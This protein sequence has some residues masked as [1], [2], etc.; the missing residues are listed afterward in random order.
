[1]QVFEEDKTHF[2]IRWKKKLAFTSLK[3]YVTLYTILQ[4]FSQVNILKEYELK[5]ETLSP[6][7]NLFK[8]SIRLPCAHI[9]KWRA[10]KN[11]GLF[12][13]DLASHWLFYKVWPSQNIEINDLIWEDWPENISWRRDFYY[14]NLKTIFIL[15]P[16]VARAPLKANSSFPISIPWPI[17]SY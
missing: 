9:L 17:S 13:N 3:K 16:V 6:C 8:R 7:T 4:I 12:L 2:S 11:R 1:M 10:L 5:D 15:K 14:I